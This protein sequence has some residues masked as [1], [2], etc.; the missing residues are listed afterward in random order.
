MI[1]LDLTMSALRARAL[2]PRRLAARAVGTTAASATVCRAAF[3]AAS[4]AKRARMRSALSIIL[5]L[6]SASARTARAWA[7]TQAALQAMIELV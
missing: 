4:S 1:T 5:S 2:P 7:V 3:F 6:C